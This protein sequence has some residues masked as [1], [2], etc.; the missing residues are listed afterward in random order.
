MSTVGTYLYGFTDRQ[1]QPRSELRGL[2]G[3]PVRTV[4][5]R[6]VAAVVSRHPVQ[7]LMPL[8]SNLEPHHRIARLVSGEPT[9]LPAAFGHISETDSS[10]LPVE[11]DNCE[12]IRRELERPH[13]K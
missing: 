11:S 6:D 10:I 13:Q 1:F 3:A 4:A 12:A 8:R 5:F 2:G 7:R 9:P